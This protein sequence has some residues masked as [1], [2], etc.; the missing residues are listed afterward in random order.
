MVEMM[1]VTAI[2][3]I[4]YAVSP[5]SLYRGDKEKNDDI[6]SRKV[7][8]EVKVKRCKV[9]IVDAGC[10]IIRIVCIDHPLSVVSLLKQREYLFFS[11][12]PAVDRERTNSEVLPSSANL[13]CLIDK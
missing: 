6:S 9:V 4:Q 5:P 7:S 12:A 1:R 11:L 13:L 8:D 2:R 10:T 3:L